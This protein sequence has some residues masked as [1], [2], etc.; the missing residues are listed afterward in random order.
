[1]CQNILT[2]LKIMNIDPSCRAVLRLGFP[3]AGL[4]EQRV[5][6]PSGVWLSGLWWVL[7]VVRKGLYGG[8]SFVQRRSTVCGVSNQVWSQETSTMRRPRQNRAVQPL[9]KK[10]K[11]N[12]FNWRIVHIVL[13][14]HRFEDRQHV[15]CGKLKVPLLSD[16]PSYQIRILATNW[17]DLWYQSS[18]TL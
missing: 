1:M 7:C 18:L 5:R 12:R 4:K 2:T 16:S 3:A 13:I 15:F 17:L 11:T 14:H 8:Q 9:K 10:L 6:I